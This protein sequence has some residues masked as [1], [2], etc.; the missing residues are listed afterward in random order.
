MKHI[1]I[2]ECEPE[3]PEK[4]NRIDRLKRVRGY[5]PK[6]VGH[7]MDIVG[8]KVVYTTINDRNRE[9]TGI[10]QSFIL[11]DTDQNQLSMFLIENGIEVRLDMI[12]GL[13]VHTND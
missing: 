3:N 1:H 11:D 2:L 12:F 10:I 4:E 7:V 9:Q 6:K 5:I 13:T 8:K